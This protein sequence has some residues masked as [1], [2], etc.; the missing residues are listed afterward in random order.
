[1][2]IRVDLSSDGAGISRYTRPAPRL[3]DRYENYV[4]GEFVK[5]A[6][7]AIKRVYPTALII[8]RIDH[9]DNA[10]NELI[11][12]R[13]GFGID[14]DLGAAE[15]QFIDRESDIVLAVKDILYNVVDKN[16]AYNHEAWQEKQDADPLPYGMV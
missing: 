8:F 13:R 5:S 1:M 9:I 4:R 14:V 11:T 16:Y 7:E 10:D 12:K 6:T 3:A 15:E 2:N